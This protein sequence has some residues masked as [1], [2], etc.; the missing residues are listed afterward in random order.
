[1][2]LESKISSSICLAGSLNYPFE[3]RRSQEFGS[4]VEESLQ[5][6]C[7]VVSV[8]KIKVLGVENFLDHRQVSGVELHLLFS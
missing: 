2:K 5:G 6:M 4:S 3:K 7:Q 8:A 1:M